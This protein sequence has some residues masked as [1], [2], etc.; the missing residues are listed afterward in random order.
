M[1][2]AS[3][4]TLMVFYEQDLEDV[5]LQSIPI[6][7]AYN[8][9]NHNTATKL[10]SQQEFPSWKIQQCCMQGQNIIKSASI[11]NKQ[12]VSEVVSTKLEGCVSSIKEFLSLF[13]MQW[14]ECTSGDDPM[15]P[16][17]HVP[18]PPCEPQFLSSLSERRKQTTDQTTMTF[19]TFPPSPAPSNLPPPPSFLDTPTSS[20]SFHHPF[21]QNPPPTQTGEKS[22][23]C[24]V[25]KKE[26]KRTNDLR[27]HKINQHKMGNPFICL[28]CSKSYSNQRNLNQHIKNKHQNQYR[29]TCFKTQKSGKKCKLQ[30]DS[31]DQ[32]VTHN[33]MYHR[34]TPAH[35]FTCE[36]CLKSFAGK[37]LLAKHIKHSMCDVMKNYQCEHCRKKYK[38]KQSLDKH[39]LLHFPRK[40]CNLCNLVLS[41]DKVLIQKHMNMHLCYV[42]PLWFKSFNFKSFSIYFRIWNNSSSCFMCSTSQIY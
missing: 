29:Y 23:V 4:G 11:V 32:Y 19:E 31:K 21:Q 1:T 25:C 20:Q 30:T 5:Y 40:K 33:V 7:L 22:L 37:G 12:F 26:F 16:I 8:K 42:A 6:V 17:L 15:G 38:Q 24:E 28:I 3:S 35:D 9:V 18:S 34:A 14:T 36:K 2:V 41:K 13:A 27:D 10:I 39:M